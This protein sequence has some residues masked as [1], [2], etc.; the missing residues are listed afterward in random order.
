VGLTPKRQIFIAKYIEYNF[1]ATKAALAAGYSAKTA[2]SIGHELL[3]NDEIK[4][5]IQEVLDSA[6]MPANE[7]LMRLAAQA[8]GSMED[9]LDE[10][11]QSI[12][13]SAAERAAKL[14]LIKKFTHSIGK[15]TENISIEL[16]DAQAALV[17]LGRYHKLFTDNTDLT[18]GGQPVS[19]VVQGVM[20]NDHADDLAEKVSE[21]SGVRQQ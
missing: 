21:A 15:E 14:H 7:V 9:F 20:D 16:Y 18:T 8:R 5:R 3:K 1:N 17:Q 19:F 12:D 11:R 13:L 6:A 10:S 4:A 2:Y